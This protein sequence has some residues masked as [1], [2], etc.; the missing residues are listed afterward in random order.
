[1]E[2]QKGDEVRTPP[3][4]TALIKFGDGSEVIMMPDAKVTIESIFVWFGKVIVRAKGVFKSKTK[5]VTAGTQST[6]YVMSTDENDQSTV[7]MVEGSVLLTSNENN[8]P[9]RT[10][11][12]GQ[13]ASVSGSEP[14]VI[15][16][17]RQD[18]YNEIVRFINK[19]TESIKGRKAKVFVPKVTYLQEAGARSLLDSAGLRVGK[20][21]KTISDD[22]LDGDYGIGTVVDQ[23]PAPGKE[24]KRGGSVTIT[25]RV[26]DVGVP[27]V[28]GQSRGAAT[29]MIQGAGLLVDGNVREEIT[30]RHEAGTVIA[31][32][33]PAGQRV[34][35]GT[36]VK[37]T[38]EAVS[39]VVPNVTG[40][41]VEQA[42]MLLRERGL[43][44]RTRPSGLREDIEGPQVVGQDPTGGGRVRPGSSVTINVAKPGV[45]VP[46]LVGQSNDAARKLLAGAD[47]RVG[48][49]S[50]QPNERPAN[51]VANQ[52]PAGGQLVERNSAVNFTVSQGPRIVTGP[53]IVTEPFI[54]ARPNLAVTNV[55]FSGSA[56]TYFLR[57]EGQMSRPANIG[58]QIRYGR[59]AEW[60]QRWTLS[61]SQLD[62]LNRGTTIRD[63]RK[64]S[65]PAWGEGQYVIR[66]H[67][68]FDNQIAE[69]NEQ[70]NSRETTT[71]TIY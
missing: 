44:V 3:G 20:V 58:I 34:M 64:I 9:S 2:L 19:T 27:G 11:P 15:E 70:D 7:T 33:P 13:E 71:Q 48:G 67:A 10:L 50:R 61:Q 39:I 25:V 47:L 63:V 38:V 46:N 53:L 68:D 4:V 69:T 65:I 1:M 21:I 41:S 22:Y 66:V 45:R 49:V 14:P 18:K 30:G 54:V 12:S 31:Q 51:I 26:R 8:W 6:L 56:L 42:Q 37:L 40:M 62:Q 16:T 35:E 52:S 36:T 28:I 43:A 23:K 17:M 59:R 5:D 57:A 32:S 60:V 29:N 55:A 24:I